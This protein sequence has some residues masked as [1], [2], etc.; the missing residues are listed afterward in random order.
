M[1][2]LA[3]GDSITR[4]LNANAGG[5][6]S[7]SYARWIA[8]VLATNA[9][10]LADAGLTSTQVLDRFGAKIDGQHTHGFVYVG[11][12]DALSKRWDPSRLAADHAALLAAVADHAETVATLTIPHFTGRMLVSRSRVR[13]ANEIIRK[14]AA[15]AGAIVIELDDLGD[16]GRRYVWADLI[17]PTSWGQVAI[18]DRAA[19]ALGLVGQPSSLAA[20]DMTGAGRRYSAWWTWRM[21]KYAVRQVLTRVVRVFR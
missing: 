9:V 10:I 8:D 3:V 14:N 19:A 5:L 11:V 18:A 6:E 16:L 1:T 15:E 17:H 2:V 12:N 13:A 7:K 4:G 20:E 21:V